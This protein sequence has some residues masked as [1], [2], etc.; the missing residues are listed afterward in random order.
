MGSVS[1]L[2]ADWMTRGGVPLFWP[3]KLGSACA[4]LF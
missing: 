4:L 3:K 1:H 2:V